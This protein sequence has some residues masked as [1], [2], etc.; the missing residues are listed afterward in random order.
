MDVGLDRILSYVS[1]ESFAVKDRSEEVLS[2]DETSID[3][4]EQQVSSGSS[5][6]P[7][8]HLSLVNSA[9]RKVEIGPMP[10][11]FDD[12]NN[13]IILTFQGVKDDGLF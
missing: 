8:H 5:L 3:I 12:I 11:D 1:L 13:E 2:F 7:K 10:Y 9:R 4:I 6:H